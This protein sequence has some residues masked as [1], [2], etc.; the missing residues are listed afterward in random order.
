M[1]RVE[2]DGM[3]ER[4]EVKSPGQLTAYERWEVPSLDGAARSA[5]E[6]TR[7]RLPTAEELEQLRRQVHEEAYASGHAQGLQQGLNEGRQQGQAEVTAQAARLAAIIQA[8]THP[9]EQQQQAIASEVLD[10]TRQL[11][12]AVIEQELRSSTTGLEALIARAL[13][14]IAGQAQ[15]LSLQLNPEDAALLRDQLQATQGWQETWRI[16]DNP[17][18][19]PGGCIIETPLHYIDARLDLRREQVFAV[20]DPAHGSA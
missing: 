11:A 19:S 18:L 12:Q 8:Y 15:S 9:L 4:H 7:V 13:Q 10:L 16:I 3:G 17:L 1:E 6:K 20:L 14:Q 2:G 5:A